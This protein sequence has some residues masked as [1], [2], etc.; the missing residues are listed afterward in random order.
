MN[1][2]TDA[3]GQAA[4]LTAVVPFLL[5]TRLCLLGAHF[6]GG[7]NFQPYAVRDGHL[8]TSQNPASSALVASHML[9]ALA[10]SA[11]APGA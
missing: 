4:G 5:E 1:G 11:A 7:P 6:E 10:Q 2:F 9:E 3:E 8:V